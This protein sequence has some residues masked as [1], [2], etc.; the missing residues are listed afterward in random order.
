[1]IEAGDLNPYV[2]ADELGAI[3][4]IEVTPHQSRQHSQISWFIGYLPNRPA[5]NVE[6][7]AAK[8]A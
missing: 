8:G 4:E 1:M 6:I 7:A 3:C 5:T 2:V